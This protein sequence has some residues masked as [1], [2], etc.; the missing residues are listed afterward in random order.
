SRVLSLRYMPGKFLNA[1]KPE[2]ARENES[3]WIGL[4]E[5]SPARRRMVVRQITGQFARRIACS[6]RPGET[7]E[8][9]QKFG[10]I[11]LGSRTELILP[12]AEGLEIVAQMGQRVK[13]GSSILAKYVE[14]L[15]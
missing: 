10:M 2:S 8:R 12:A 13:A 14:S 9:G 15:S 5:L 11:K 4:E 6:Q 1:L 3:M 7:L